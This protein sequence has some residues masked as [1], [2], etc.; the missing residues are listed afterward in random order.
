MSRTPPSARTPP[1]TPPSASR[2]TKRRLGDVLETVS[3]SSP[4]LRSV[5]FAES[6]PIAAFTESPP[7]SPSPRASISHDLPGG[8]V[9]SGS[10]PTIEE[11]PTTPPRFDDQPPTPMKRPRSR[12]SPADD[13]PGLMRADSLEDLK[14]LKERTM[15]RQACAAYACWP[16]P[17]VWWLRPC[18]WS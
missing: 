15:T 14:V 16:R 8:N 18:V 3:S 12:L 7:R 4:A 10:L 1:L 11:S 5:M 13:L 9:R 17:L 6:K 2:G